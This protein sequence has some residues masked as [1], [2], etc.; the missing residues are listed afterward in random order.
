M[1]RLHPAEIQINLSASRGSREEKMKLTN[2]QI[3]HHRRCHHPR[4]HRHHFHHRHQHLIVH[5]CHL[6]I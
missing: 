2:I 6:Q 3:H 5:R 4:R 1:R